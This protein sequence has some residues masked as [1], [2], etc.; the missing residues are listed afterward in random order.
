VAGNTFA[1]HKV[2][3]QVTDTEGFRVDPVAPADRPRIA[4]PAR[5]PEGIDAMIKPGERRG[6]QHIIVDEWGP[7]DWRT[8]KL[9]PA[10]RSDETP[11]RLRVLGP[12]ST[13]S[14][15]SA[16]GASVDRRSGE[17]PGEVTVTPA[18]GRVVDWE[19]VLQGATSRRFSYSRFFVPIDWTVRFYDLGATPDAPVRPEGFA[20]LV[21]RPPFAT[22][23][24]DRLDYLSSRAIVEG[25]P[26]N[27]VAIVAEGDAVMPPGRFTLRTISDDG[28]RVWVDGTLAIDNWAPHESVVDTAPISGGRRRLRVEYYERTGFAELRVEIVK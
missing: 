16:R 26:N 7:Y 6:R 11:L 21:A 10:G 2:P 19:L 14:L 4:A 25:A 1:G 17:I 3:F 15:V 12:P 5:M 27:H 23:K 8:P 22:E 24:T 9:W 13:W 20:G 18:P 28:V